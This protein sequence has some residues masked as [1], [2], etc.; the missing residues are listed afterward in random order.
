MNIDPEKNVFPKGA[1]AANSGTTQSDDGNPFHPVAED[2][3]RRALSPRQ[4]QMIAI[5][6]TIG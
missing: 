2:N 3:L 5:G 6:G 1:N 4:V